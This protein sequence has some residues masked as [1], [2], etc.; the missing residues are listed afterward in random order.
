MRTTKPFP[1]RVLLTVTTGRLLTKP[2][3][4]GGNGIGDLYKILGWMTDDQPFTHQLPRFS[5]ECKPWLLRWFPEL[6][7]AN[8]HLPILDKLLE[9]ARAVGQPKKAIENAVNDWLTRV[10]RELHLK[11]TYD[12]PKIPRDD[13]DVKDPFDELVVMRGTDEGITIVVVE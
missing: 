1:A 5:D 10:T 9:A 8:D 2:D 6:A 13:H 12:V 4:D 7:K 3:S 11:K